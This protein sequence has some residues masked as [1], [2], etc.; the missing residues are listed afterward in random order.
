MS[1]VWQLPRNSL[2]WLLIAQLAVILPHLGLLPIWVFV[3]FFLA[4]LS[5]LMVF[6]GRWSMPRPAVKTLLALSCM[7]GVYYSYGSFLGLEPTVTLLIAG[8]AL[9]LVEAQQRRDFYALVFLAYFVALTA[10]LFDQSLSQTLYSFI[11]VLLVTT[12]LVALHHGDQDRLD[13]QSF[14][15]ALLLFAQALPLMVVLFAVFPRFD[16]LWQVP[17]PGHQASTGV[18]DRL[19]PGDISELLKDSRLAFRANFEGPA[20]EVNQLYWRGL[21]MS[22]FDGREWRPGRNA[23]QPRKPAQN[24]ADKIAQK[25]QTSDSGQ[26]LSYRIIQE[27]SYKPWLFALSLA[28]SSDQKIIATQDYRLQRNSDIHERISYRVSSDI[29]AR[30][31]PQLSAEQKNYQTRLPAGFNPRIR[32]WVEEQ[33]Q[34]LTPQQFVALVLQQFS[35]QPFAYTLSPATLGR[36][37]VDDFFFETQ[38]GFC[39][40]YAS[41]FV[42]MVRAAGIPARVVTGYL[43]GELNPL[44]QSVLVHQ[45]TAHA[46]AEVW[47]EGEGWRRVD[48][49]SAVAPERVDQGVEQALGGGQ[50][51]SERPFSP[52]RYRHLIWINKMRMQLDALN[53]YWV[54]SV[55]N[56]NDDSQHNFLKSLLG[57]INPLRIALLL[58]A[59]AGLVVVWVMWDII[60]QKLI[61][62]R[63]R[64]DRDYLLLCQK[65]ASLGLVRA[66]DEGPIDFARRVSAQQQLPPELSLLFM[67]A[68]RHY[69][70]LCYQKNDS[71]ERK[72]L[73][74]LLR[75]DSRNF[76]RKMR[77]KI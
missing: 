26:V 12:A 24:N 38:Q 61:T 70:E 44:T 39:G 41:S 23:D 55:I 37:S 6:Q 25:K 67:S 14:K 49:T 72:Q 62:A 10:F 66:D 56:Y 19:S 53:Y 59:V 31:E 64:H 2:A 35:Q 1:S 63:R 21:V 47:F 32:Q 69:V 54:S 76:A 8:F 18:S 34:G 74:K 48:P 28:S 73:Q 5:R 42:F 16:P 9:K 57:E 29:G 27:A 17:L 15:K 3:V 77:I 51:L 4:G 11:A 40:H 75:Q 46:W 33:K 52:V 71:D 7:A 65:V 22:V 13:G 68:T 50:F 20:P 60:R 58:I 36:H 43:G 45:F 30:F